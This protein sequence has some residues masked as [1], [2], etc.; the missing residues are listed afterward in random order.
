MAKDTRP[1]ANGFVGAMRKVYNPLGFSKGY[2]FVLFFITMGYLFGFTLSRL[3]YLSFHGVFC[4]P[5]SSGATGAAPGECYYYLQ[6]PYKIGIQLH[7]YTILPAALLVVLQF[8][9]IIRHKLRLFHRLN[10]YL[11]I[12]LSLISSAGVIMILPHAFGGDFAIQTYGGA[13]VISTTLAYLMAYVNIK[14][15]QIDQHRAWMFRAWAYFSTIITLRLIQIS[16]GAIIS[17]LGGWYVSRPCAQINSI[18]GQTETLA[19]YPS[20]SSFYDGTSPSQHVA[21]AAGFPKGTAVEIAAAMG[22]TF[23]AAGWLA[24]WLHVTMVEIYLRMTPA[25]SD[26]L[27]QVSYERQLAR[28]SKRPGY[29]GLVAEHF[30]DAKPY[31][32]LAPEMLTKALD[33]ESASH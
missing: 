23:G 18:L 20:C 12:T 4:N 29:A 26:R 7:L 32:P 24:L 5:H 28:G 6:N 17:L 14:L 11:V 8:V 30:G 13:L 25:E 31:V 10:G 33:V 19:A 22:V 21:V 27:R 9:P 2:N 3:E 1:P 16:A 15:L